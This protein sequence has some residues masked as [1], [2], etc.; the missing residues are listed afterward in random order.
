MDEAE[1]PALPGRSL[2]RRIAKWT[3][4]ALGGLL[5]L[6]L[7]AAWGIDTGPGH[8]F[9]ADRIAALRPTN[10]LR[11]RIGRIE[12]SIWTRATIRDLRLYDRRG[13]FLQ[14]PAVALDWRPAD[15]LANRLAINRLD[16]DLVIL[17]KIPDLST[18]KKGPIL[19][20]FD[21]RIGALN[22]TRLRL[23][24]AVAGARRIVALTGRADIRDG[25]A[26][27]DLKAL[28]AAKDGLTLKLDAEPDRDRFDLEARA[29]SPA[30]G[31][32]GGIFG[33]K[34][35]LAL[36]ITGKGTWKRWQGRA[37]YTLS[38]RQVVD[39][40][41]TAQDG[42]YALT[43]FAA[44]SPFLAGKLQRMTAPRIAMTGEATLKDRRLDLNFKAR[45]AALD[46]RV[47]GAADLS[48]STFDAM[49]VDARLLR[50]RAMF[51]NMSGRDIRLN[52][53]FDGPFKTATFDYAATA[54]RLAF[55]N[56]GFETV[57]AAG[58]GQ[59]SPW[60][61]TLPVRFTAARV[62]GIGEVGGGILRNL[63]VD[64]ALRITPRSL[65]GDKLKLSSDKLAGQLS[66]RL[67]MTTGDYDVALNGQISR[68][69]IPGIG[70]VDVKSE[71]KV[72]PGTSGR[73]TVVSGTGVAVVRRL[74]NSFFRS[75][76][77]G[78]PRIETGL[79]RGP[80]G[81][82]HFRNL[83]LRGPGITFAG[84]GYRRNDGTFHVEGS[85]RQA[86][87]GA[88]RLL[89]DG[90][91]SRPRVVLKL[92]SP[93]PALGLTDVDAVLDPT[94]AGFAFRARGGSTLG[95]F[96]TNGAILLPAGAPA[97]IQFADIAVAGTHG[98][99]ALTTGD[100]GFSG[101][102]D[103]AGGGI[104]GALL[105]MPAD[106]VQ[107]IEAHLTL[108][109]ASLGAP[110]NA[111]IGRAKIDGALRLDPAGISVDGTVAARGIRRGGITIQRLDASAHLRGGNG[112]VRANLS[113]TQ[114]RGFDLKTV[115]TLAPNRISIRADGTVDRRPVALTTPAVLTA[116]AGGWRLAPTAL[117]FGGGSANVSGLFGAES[118]AA[119]LSL[120]KMPLRIL[121]LV[122]PGI[123]LSGDASGRLTFRAAKGARPT[124]NANLTVRGL[125]RAALARAS[126]PVDIGI[127]GVLD[128][129][130][131]A[132]RAVLASS[133][134]TLG[135]GQARLAPIG[136]S[137]SFLDD[138][139][140]A[141]LFAQF[142]YQGPAGSL[143]GLSGL[144][145]VDLTGPLSVGADVSG[146]L[147]D[148]VIRGSVR[149]TGA[150]LESAV[151]GTVVTDL[152]ATGRFDG[153]RLLIDRFTGKTPGNGALSG[154]ATFDFASARGFGMDVAIQ[155]ENARLL[156]RDDIGATVT[157][158]LAIR[159]D[160][161]AGTISGDVKLIRSSFRL[162]RAAAAEVPQLA[163]TEINRDDTAPGDRAAAGG[164]WRLDLQANARNRLAV[165]GLGLDSEWQADMKIGGTIDAP[166]IL[167]TATLVR[168][169]YEFAGRRFELERGTIRF[170]GE[171]PPDPQ[172]DI[173]AEADIQGLNATIRVTGTGLHPDI[174]FTS[175]PALPEDE[176][177]S[178]L[179]FGTSIT[180]LS[181]PEAVQL[182]AAVASLRSGGG[183]G[184]DPI[185]AVR[186][187]AGLDRLRILP[188][189]QTTG[190]KASVAAGKYVTR[191]VYVEVATDG[192]GYSATR[193]E[194]ELTRWLSLLSSISSLG[195][196]STNV[197]IS[198]DY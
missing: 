190:Q 137:G 19:P 89:L 38:D 22:V 87:Y 180:N 168:G 16:S 138:L 131:A 65:T 100:V 25:R 103:L 79:L 75:L 54:S 132:A 192:Q 4:I 67:D 61:V 40:S 195:R 117:S 155:A 83:R 98:K 177:L 134:Q 85:G 126:T 37:L 185:N 15:W 163:V 6:I 41:L 9:L 32:L 108:A 33:T 187:A 194:W 105:F 64:G 114:G 46:L 175:V 99:G 125:S 11:I 139:M 72:V 173:S 88:F 109:G 121:D 12:G 93:L 44:P 101:R 197:R 136:N 127:V 31:T 49:R 104:G 111:T 77:G 71:L 181:A 81:V 39:L 188:A 144:E 123:G 66:L 29:T 20:G 156:A 102:I 48:D 169:G 166:R 147:S 47:A 198:K 122:M 27:V 146:R 23:E 115:T 5:L 124:G 8:R 119:D 50:P 42:R 161:G 171:Y 51:P 90:D 76:A 152:N 36:T 189:D 153:S 58:K 97:T 45:S 183:G 43:G 106:G 130:G 80:D 10:G 191:R 110:A 82:L 170:S 28:A 86:Q 162:G 70:I 165:T 2:L 7:V 167:G 62:T 3:A 150:R 91:I 13:L 154:R 141:P 178:R 118:T 129:R 133:G 116:E 30:A 26:M 78:L 143:W 35:P 196:T 145:I 69:L 140:A 135:R 53:R 84:N 149:A 151:T 68:Y 164:G 158:P 113:G 17:S 60:P 24:P 179:L 1:A 182:A 59:L 184:L 74:D 56:T 160:G 21:I 14:S 120:S 148:P 186:K 172:L 73:G 174:S 107:R 142:R 157:G 95:P 96:A 63:T 176:L 34:R 112:E 159:S 18:G 57:R 128:A 193:V 52:A 55:D 94:A 92:A